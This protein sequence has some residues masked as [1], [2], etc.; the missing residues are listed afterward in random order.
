MQSY[1]PQ[2]PRSVMPLP[3]QEALRT[4]G[5]AL[6]VGRVPRV[7]IVVDAQG[8]TIETT[9]AFGVRRYTWQ[10]IEVQSRAQQ[11]HRRASGRPAPWMD[12]MAVTRW[13]VLLRLVGRL[14]D[15]RGVGEC[16]ID[17][18][19]APANAPEACRVQV[20]VGQ[21]VIVDSE[22]VRLHLLRLRTRQSEAA[23][24]VAVASARPW[25]AFWRRA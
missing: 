12:P 1:P 11:Q 25:W 5:L 24:Q 4:V 21:R 17:A 14:L 13:S 2:G 18:A 3:L 8:V 6:E 9:T 15:T 23:P 20:R 10:E 7:Q 22:A 16:V 19:P